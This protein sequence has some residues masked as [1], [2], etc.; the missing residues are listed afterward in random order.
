MKNSK[1][2]ISMLIIA[3][4]TLIMFVGCS[5]YKKMGNSS[6]AGTTNNADAGMTGNTNNEQISYQTTAKKLY[7]DTLKPLVIDGTITQNQSDKVLIAITKNMVSD[8]GTSIGTPSPGTPR[9]TTPNKNTPST[10]TPSIGTPGASPSG[11]P[12]TGTTG[13]KMLPNITELSKLV[14]SGVIT[15]TQANTINQKLQDATITG[16]GSQTE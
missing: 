11:T 3:S 13:G 7:S 6:N 8:T 2:N 10:G 14:K 4:L 9:T 5:S 12:G 1:K 15:Q 16:Q